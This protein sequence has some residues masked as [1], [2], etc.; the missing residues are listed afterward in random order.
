MWADAPKEINKLR[1]WPSETIENRL[2]DSMAV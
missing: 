2:T 1:F